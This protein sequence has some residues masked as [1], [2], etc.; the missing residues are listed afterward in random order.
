MFR[1]YKLRGL[2]MKTIE[3]EIVNIS[4]GKLSRDSL[5]EIN[6]ADINLTQLRKN[7]DT[8][9]NML[10]P[11]VKF[12][13]VTK[14]D[15]YGHGIVPIAEE[16]ERCGCHAIGVVRL[17]EAAVLRE[18]G[19]KDPILMLSPLMPSQVP[20]IVKH[21]ITP[22]VD[23]E[24]IIVALENCGAAQGKVINV[25]VK[26]N[27][28]LNRYGVEVQDAL[29]FIYKI[30]KDCPHIKIE[31]IFTHF[32]DPEYN[33]Q[34]TYFQLKRFD[35]VL[36]DLQREGL[37]PAIAHAAGSV[38]ILMYPESH[39]DMVRCGLILYGIEPKEDE[40]LLPESIKPLMTIKSRILKIDNIK[41]GESGGYGSKFT[42]ERDSS[43]AVVGIGY[44]DGISRGWKEVLV[45]GQRVPVINYFMDGILVDITDVK[46]VVKEFDEVILIGNE[47]NETITWEEASNNI[48]TFPDEQLQRITQRV[49]KYYFYEP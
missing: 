6:R 19:I 28:G 4:T 26:V 13:G 41:A 37:R 8:I 30:N 48:N 15:A 2:N 34:F 35:K 7:I 27:T 36:N 16:L 42:A 9:R 39:Y 25:H 46:H 17:M 24:E 43:L 14:G 40:K 44:G 47:N 45:A 33:P 31:G 21:N 32:K 18:A 12:M 23:N 5:I 29:G 10:K 11:G 20:W 3:R 38:G 1:N 22:M 49:P